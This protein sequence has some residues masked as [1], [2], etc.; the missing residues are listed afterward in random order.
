[1]LRYED[2]ILESGKEMALYY[3][4][5][6]RNILKAIYAKYEGAPERI[7]SVLIL[8]ESGG[9][10]NY[11]Y[12][13]IDVTEKNDKISFVQANRYLKEFPDG[14]RPDSDNKFWKNGRTLEYSVGKFAQ[15]VMKNVLKEVPGAQIEE[16]VNA[17]RT[18]YDLARKKGDQTFKVVRGREI[19]TRYIETSFVEKNKFPGHDSLHGSCMRKTSCAGFFEIYIDNPD[20]CE[21]LVMLDDEGKTM[22]RA[23][24]W[25]LESGDR[26]M[27]RIYCVDT[28][29]NIGKFY[30]WAKTNG[31]KY[32]NGLTPILPFDSTVRVKAKSYRYYPYMDTFKFYD[33]EQGLLT[34]E[35]SSDDGV[36]Y[37][38]STHGGG[39]LLE[40]EFRFSQRE[41]RWLDVDV[42]CYCMDID[43]YVHQDDAI[44]LEYKGEYVSDAAET[45]YSEY[46]EQDYLA[47]DAVRSEMMDDYIHKDDAV[48][49]IVDE[50]GETD[51]CHEK[52]TAL[53]VKVGDEYYSKDY[54]YDPIAKEWTFDAREV[55]ERLGWELV[56]S[57]DARGESGKFDKGLLRKN[58]ERMLVEWK[59]YDM[60]IEEFVSDLFEGVNISYSISIDAVFTSNGHI[61]EKRVPV[62]TG[63]IDLVP[64]FVEW[65]AGCGFDAHSMKEVARLSSEIYGDRKTSFT[66]KDG[67]KIVIDTAKLAYKSFE[68]LSYH[69]RAGAIFGQL[70]MDRLVEM[71]EPGLE[72]YKRWLVLSQ[73]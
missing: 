5:E 3:S 59:G 34:R 28:N 4:D 50:D 30:D 67:E 57:G 48:E 37:L 62:T 21:L 64:A 69:S 18:E 52:E 73:W 24:L 72:I 14:E 2:F 32:K 33:P 53:Y 15:T 38:Q 46:D 56:E 71:P 36:L 60:S 23:L 47:E 16:F 45:R 6:F 66:L 31:I 35:F 65:I 13:L 22:G 44:W 54:T 19:E 27:D 26:Y 1:M 42:A 8:Q 41:N 55:V 11:V 39:P 9:Q 58:F 68:M 61:Q 43:D 70:R 20:V 40:D 7:A 49:V 51:W 63:I 10:R 25:T 29:T 12:S 17:Y